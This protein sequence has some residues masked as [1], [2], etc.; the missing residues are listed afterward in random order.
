MK[1]SIYP[2]YQMRKTRTEQAGPSPECP[3]YEWL[4]VG[5]GLQGCYFAG[6]LSH[7]CGRGKVAI[8]DPQP[9]LL[10]RWLKRSDACHMKYM[11]STSMHHLAPDPGDLLDFARISGYGE[12]HFTEPYLRPSLTLFNAHCRRVLETFRLGEIH[13]CGRLC[14]LS[15]LDSG[16]WQV[17]YLDTEDRESGLRS[18]NILLALGDQGEY[19]PDSTL[20]EQYEQSPHL[21]SVDFSFDEV[22]AK[23]FRW[24]ARKPKQASDI[25]LVGG[26]ISSAQMA[27]YLLEQGL[28]VQIDSRYP[29][30][31]FQFDSDPGWLFKFLPKFRAETDLQKRWQII[32]E[33]R[34]KGSV[35]PRL[36]ESL[37]GYQ[38]QGRLLLGS[39]E[40]RDGSD[41]DGFGVCGAIPVV[42]A[43][44]LRYETPDWLLEVARELGLPLLR[45]AAGEKPALDSSLEWDSERA[46]GLYL[47]GRLA[48]LFLG[49]S[50]GNISGARVA[51]RYLP[52]ESEHPGSFLGGG[53]YGYRDRT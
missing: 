47:T 16:G 5:G 26:G 4:I 43:T 46:P 49:P 24:Q 23:T 20:G 6:L 38:Q 50:A 21:S 41:S 27:L 35:P 33:E 1:D 53:S 37:L 15:K 51:A 7:L 18:Q 2:N 9:R 29:L 3:E 17:R 40:A 19:R 30:R 11:R 52:I 12:E 8:L 45:T 22:L 25:C 32:M 48:E 44:G 39:R 28:K 13:I 14:R 10:H 34:H 42:L 31:S 36:Y